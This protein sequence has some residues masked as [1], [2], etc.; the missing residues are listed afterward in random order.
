MRPDPVLF[1]IAA[2]LC[3][4]ALVVYLQ[5]RALRA[6]DRQTTA[7]V[8]KV[9]EQTVESVT[10]EIRG[11]FDGPV[12]DTI[13]SI[14][15]PYL[16][17]NRLD[18]VALQFAKG[19]AA[20]PQVE[21]FVVWT[22]RDTE[23]DVKDVRFFGD[24][25]LGAEEIAT[26]TDRDALF[27]SDPVLATHVLDAARL[28]GRSQKIYAAS[29]VRVDGVPYEV[30]VRVLYTDAA[31]RHYFAVLGFVVNLE[32][33]R[34]TLFPALFASRLN[35]L[36]QAER[37]SVSFDMHVDDESGLRVF[38]PSGS[39][40]PTTSARAA[41]A[42][43]FYPADDIR[44]RM[45][46]GVRAPIWTVTVSPHAE[47]ASALMATTRRQSAW[48]SG[49]S[50]TLMLVALGFAL[51]GNRRARQLARMQAEFVAHVS[52]QLKTP[53]SLLSA[54]SE[55]LGLDRVRSPEKL[56]QFLEIVRL[57]V[58]HL[59][60]LVERILDFSRVSDG[61]RRYE[62]EAVALVPLVSETVESFA[63]AVAPVGFSI[64]VD[65]TTARPIVAADP[66]ALEQALV[67]LLDNA[68]KYSGDSRRIEV[69]V[70]ASAAEAAI[71]VIDHGIG[72]ARG[73]R[74]AVFHRFYRG[75][76]AAVNRQGFGLGLA[77]VRE[78]VEGQRGS[79]DLAA[80][81]PGR[82]S[83]F[84]IRIP[85]LHGAPRQ[86]SGWVGWWDA[87][88]TRRVRQSGKT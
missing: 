65:A 16:V 60:S 76:G 56:S 32:K 20:Y 59:S 66:M 28:P 34:T 17:D 22:G 81:E 31:R 11:T 71:D 61:G 84:R 29:S 77:L 54:A 79:V 23:A 82:G 68:V 72:I 67:N 43:Q 86:V 70:H 63:R 50:V 44:T 49:A 13:A 58:K 6:L 62:I 1:M 2:L 26:A 57:E 35:G 74:E 69:R 53:V 36:L 51:Q 30:F 52:H 39:A 10:H 9:A 8:Q 4:A 19:L 25:T 14:N 27:T 55:T 73:E 7:L 38:G 75:A 37:G 64:E 33:V 42:M 48:L 80:S 87:W 15:H 40:S 83:T 46:S 78:L 24:R 21:Q 3:A 5:D 18:L 41:V 85:I 45:A 88:M 47:Q 12:F